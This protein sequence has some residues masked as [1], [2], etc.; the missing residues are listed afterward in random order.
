[1]DEGCKNIV[2][3]QFKQNVP[4]GSADVKPL[5][6]EGLRHGI[7]DR[8]GNVIITGESFEDHLGTNHKYLVKTKSREYFWVYDYETQVVP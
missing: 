8:L 3:A 6:S 1:M 4:L 2:K 5:L 7:H